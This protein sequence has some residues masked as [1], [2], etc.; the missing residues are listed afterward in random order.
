METLCVRAARFVAASA[1]GCLVLL[2]QPTSAVLAAG[3]DVSA[4]FGFG[5]ASRL[6]K[7]GESSE[8]IVAFGRQSGVGGEG[9]LIVQLPMGYSEIALT[10]QDEGLSCTKKGPN[11]A[12][13]GTRI[14]CMHR[15]L[16]KNSIIMFK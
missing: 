15:N 1:V 8:F 10:H 13:D 4:S 2:G 16:S 7:P 11:P 5:E 14:E 3:T 12:F 6:V 9:E